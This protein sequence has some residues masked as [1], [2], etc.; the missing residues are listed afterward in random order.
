MIF[1]YISKRDKEKIVKIYIF[2]CVLIKGISPRLSEV[3]S[4]FPLCRQEI[5]EDAECCTHSTQKELYLCPPIE[6]SVA[7]PLRSYTATP[8]I[9]SI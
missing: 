3:S 9:L 4:V 1:I 2:I 8:A 7:I 5:K 6:Y